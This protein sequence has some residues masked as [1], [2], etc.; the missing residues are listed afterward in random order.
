MVAQGVNPG[1]DADDH[2]SRPGLPYAALR[3]PEARELRSRTPHPLSPSPTRSHPPGE[4][5]PPPALNLSL[6]AAADFR[7]GRLGGGKI[8]EGGGA[9]LPVERERVGEG[10]GVRSGRG[11]EPQ[12]RD[13]E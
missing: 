12:E 13:K 5:A 2:H 1:W 9:P 10:T 11:E 8:R 3:A 7:H 4:G 6:S